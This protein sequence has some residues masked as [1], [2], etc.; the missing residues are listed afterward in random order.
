MN[1]RRPTQFGGMNERQLT[2]FDDMN[3]RQPTDGIGE[4]VQQ[5]DDPSFFSNMSQIQTWIYSRERLE[6][7]VHGSCPYHVFDQIVLK[8]RRDFD[9]VHHSNNFKFLFPRARD[10][11]RIAQREWL[12]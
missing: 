8:V 5:L 11:I 2:H 6:A 7:L 12:I 9:D 10:V 4:D 1:E 3:E